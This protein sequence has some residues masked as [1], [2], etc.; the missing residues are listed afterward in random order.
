MT[1]EA[2]KN[3]AD[4]LRERA[5]DC[6][7]EAASNLRAGDAVATI[8]PTSMANA[9]EYAAGLIDRIEADALEQAEAAP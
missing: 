6:M 9:Y 8:R 1:P 2:A 5:R 3:I 7:R 4:H